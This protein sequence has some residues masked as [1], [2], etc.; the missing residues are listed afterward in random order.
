M[1]SEAVKRT[2]FRVATFLWPKAVKIWDTDLSLFMFLDYGQSRWPQ[3]I[4]FPIWKGEHS[5]MNE[6]GIYDFLWSVTGLY[7]IHQ[8]HGGSLSFRCFLCST[9]QTWSLIGMYHG[10][11][12]QVAS[13]T[14]VTILPWFVL[15]CRLS[16][17]PSHY[18]NALWQ[19]KRV[20]HCAVSSHDQSLGYIRYKRA[21]TQAYLT[22]P[23]PRLYSTRCPDISTSMSDSVQDL[24]LITTDQGSSR[25]VLEVCISVLLVYLS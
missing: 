22:T 17:A 10:H 8:L 14:V 18:S 2:Y 7:T 24:Q 21:S 3:L 23:P 15:C 16:K 1:E 19:T 6:I 13:R 12:G 4:N 11:I 20:E 5:G 9:K 25:A